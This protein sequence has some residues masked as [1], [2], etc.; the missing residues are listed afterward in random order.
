MALC[1]LD[2]CL[3]DH[4]QAINK[5]NILDSI[6]SPIVCLLFL[7]LCPWQNVQ[8]NLKTNKINQVASQVLTPFIL[9][10]VHK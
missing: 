4:F 10:S 9:K 1:V 2:E 5:K 3:I 7:K 6:F 8:I